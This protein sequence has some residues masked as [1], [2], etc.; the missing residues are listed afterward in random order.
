MET[1]K[2]KLVELR[3][4]ME[5]DLKRYRDLSWWYYWEGRNSLMESNRRRF[6]NLSK[7]YC[8]MYRFV[9]MNL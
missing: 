6:W 4:K 8:N 3:M 9:K 7:L 2:I 1:E 5:M